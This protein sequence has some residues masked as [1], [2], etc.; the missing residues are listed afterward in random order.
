VFRFLVSAV[1]LGVILASATPAD[2]VSLTNR[3]ERTHK[4]TIIDG[5]TRSE[6]ALAPGGVMEGVCNSGCVIRLNDSEEDEY[7]LEGPEILSIEGGDI[8]YDGPD[9]PAETPP[10]GEPAR[11]SPK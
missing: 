9:S 11:P 7:E 5:E 1:G 2:A 8:Y 4:V 3:D 6:Q 10:T